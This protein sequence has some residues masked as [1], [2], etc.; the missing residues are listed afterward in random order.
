MRVSVIGGGVAG[1]AAAYDLARAGHAV[2]VYEAGSRLGGLAGSFDF[3]GDE[4]ERFYHFICRPDVALLQMAEEVGLGETIA[5]RH[6]PMG[7]F[8]DGHEYPFGTPMEL[9]RFSPVSLWDRI[10]LGLMIVRARLVTRWQTLEH[11]T[12]KEWLISLVGERAYSVVWDPLLRVKFGP[13]HDRVAAPWMWHRIH[14][15]AQSRDGLMAKERMGYFRVG[16]QMLVDRMIGLLEDAGVTVRLETPVREVV[17]EGGRVA[18]IQT[19]SGLDACDAVVSTVAPPLLARVLPAA[20][21]AFRDDL[22][23]IEYLGVACMILK[24][25]H[26]ISRNFWLNVNDPAITFNG[27]I[28][29]TNLNPRPDLNGRRIAYIPFYVETTDPRYTMSNEAMFEEYTTALARVNPAFT[30]E[31]VVDYRVF[32]DPY[33]Q[34][35]C[36]PNFSKRIPPHRAPVPGLY[37]CDST[38]LYPSDRTI[39]GMIGIGRHVATLVSEDA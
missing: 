13:H 18:G 1:I 2:T 7:Y 28:E 38:Q 29:Y 26:P 12:A 25:T 33:A 17:L 30:R 22:A 6:S 39:S 14:R 4:I 16:T 21:G 10:R 24:L 15:V 5:W 20:A 35:V 34:A 27:I 37:V 19:A 36:P 8:V 11:R 32:R 9:L 23:S 3:G 31:W